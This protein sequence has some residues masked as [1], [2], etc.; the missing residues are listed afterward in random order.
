[1]KT[2][3][4]I[5]AMTLTPAAN[6]DRLTLEAITGDK[7]LSGT[8]LM[9]PAISPDGHAVTWLQGK[10]DDRFQLD[11]WEYD[12]AS[13]RRRVLV[14]SR[15]VLPGEVLSDEEK[16]RRERQRIAAYRGIVE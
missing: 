16:A 10:D 1:M 4:L 9:K 2:L 3:L 12:I 8:L 11:L 5:A 15:V 13:G 14:D 7:P 6:A